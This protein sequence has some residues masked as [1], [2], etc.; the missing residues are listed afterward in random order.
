[1]LLQKDRSIVIYAMLYT[2]MI[3]MEMYRS[4]SLFVTYINNTVI[5]IVTITTT[6]TT[7]I[8]ML[9]TNRHS[10]SVIDRE[11]PFV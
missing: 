3:G 6:I 7:I 1:M 10:K 4:Q 11:V 5:T 2:V 8:S 9:N